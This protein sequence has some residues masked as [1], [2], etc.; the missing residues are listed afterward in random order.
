MNSAYFSLHNTIFAKIITDE[1]LSA[2][3][4]LYKGIQSDLLDLQ[5]FLV[6]FEVPYN[7]SIISVTSVLGP[8]L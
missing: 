7:Q 5:S 6:E 2:E 1:R 4:K 8:S 3:L